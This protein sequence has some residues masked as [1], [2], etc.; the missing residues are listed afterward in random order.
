MV[1]K[2]LD[3]AFHAS[4]PEL[5]GH[6]SLD[7]G[8]DQD[9]EGVGRHTNPDEDQQDREHLLSWSKPVH[10]AEPHR[11]NGDNRLEDRVQ[12]GIAERDKTNGASRQHA[13]KPDHPESKP[14]RGPDRVVVPKPTQPQGHASS[15][16]QTHPVRAL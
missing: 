12:H 1:V 14:P 16:P 11:G 6:V 3:L 9:T 5:V 7:K 2:F 13:E 8:F 4:P 10:L 15:V